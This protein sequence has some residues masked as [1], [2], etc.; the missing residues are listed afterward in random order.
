MM[1]QPRHIAIIMDGNGRWAN[2]RG[3]P[4]TAGHHQGVEACKRVVRAAGELGVEY[5]TLFGFSSENWSRPAEEV[6]ELMRLLRIFLRAETADL[7][8]NNVRLQ[9]IG[10]RKELA[11]DIVELIEN[12]EKL[13][14]ENTGLNLVIAL[15]YGGRNEI[16][17]AAANYARFVAEKG[18]TACLETAEEYFADGL[19]TAGIPDPDILIRTSGEQ[20]ISNFLLWQCAYTEFMYT[21]VLWP[22]FGKTDLENAIAD[23]QK[24]ERRYGGVVGNGDAS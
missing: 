18:L 10:S 11:D 20:R 21:T 12:T 4:R 16:L 23:F 9:V 19:M 2:Q 13:T 15:N 1:K 8:R 14:R 22:D 17:H 7:H 3:L 5:L 24:R 6:K